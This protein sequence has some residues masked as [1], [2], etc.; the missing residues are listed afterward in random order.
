MYLFDACV[1]QVLLDGH[2]RRAQIKVGLHS[3]A[4]VM[5]MGWLKSFQNLGITVGRQRDG[6]AHY[7]QEL[8]N[9][10]DYLNIIYTS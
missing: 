7:G 9:G 6:G 10:L 4:N 2:P 3:I 1:Q 8:W 5:E